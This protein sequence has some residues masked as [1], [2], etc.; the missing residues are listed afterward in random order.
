QVMHDF[1]SLYLF[2][3]TVCTR[4]RRPS[5]E[6]WQEAAGNERACR[7]R[8]RSVKSRDYPSCLARK[9][10]AV[11]HRVI[12]RLPKGLSLERRMTEPTTSPSW[13][14][15]TKSWLASSNP[16]MGRRVPAA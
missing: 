13:M 16:W 1:R 6:K 12:S 7:L 4:G 9:S 10:A 2:M 11:W 14:M 8:D 5:L 3:G 15:G